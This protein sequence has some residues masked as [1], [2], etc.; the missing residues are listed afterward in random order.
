[1]QGV[2]YANPWTYKG[3]PFDADEQALKGLEGFV[4]LLTN[5]KTNR[6][7]IG[8]KSFWQ[9][10]KPAKGGRRVTKMSDWKKYYSSSKLIKEEISTKVYLTTDFKREILH[11]CRAKIE[12]SYFE[13]KE[14]FVR[15]VLETPNHYNESIGG[16]YFPREYNGEVICEDCSGFYIT[17]RHKTI[18]QIREERS[19]RMKGDNNPSKRPEVRAKLGRSGAD[20]HRFGKTNSTEHTK[21]IVSSVKGH[22]FMN[23]DGLCKRIE[24]SNI[25]AMLEEGWVIGKIQT[26]GQPTVT[27][28]KCNKSGGASGM[29]RH[30]FENCKTV[31]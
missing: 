25:E 7:Y 13:T 22:K 17:P 14:Q 4:Y 9:K 8:K 10:R 5:T 3:Q 29:K 6:Q 28:P 31:T 15:G 19:E 1:M 12:M 2:S 21:A 27:C 23:K 26:K 24:P 20:N 16:K 30:H 18:E 11:I